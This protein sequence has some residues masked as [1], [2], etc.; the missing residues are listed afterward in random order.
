MK[1]HQIY[2]ILIIFLSFPA[3]G[4]EADSLGS[5]NKGTISSQFDWLLKASKHDL[6]YKV[7]INTSRE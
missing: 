3:F 6:D 4:Q 5:L 1:K 2:L 7:I